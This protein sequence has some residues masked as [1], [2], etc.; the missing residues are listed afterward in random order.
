M[1][2]LI[3]A[4]LISM[5]SSFAAVAYGQQSS[6]PQP[7]ITGPYTADDVS[8]GH[9]LAIMIC[10]ICHIAAADQ[11]SLPIATP[12]APPFESLAQ[13]KDITAES[14]QKF[15]TTTHRGLNNPNG[16]PNPMLMDYQMKQIV[17]YFLSLRI[18]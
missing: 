2:N 18:H 13:R 5:L 16:M 11:P 3:F 17:A 8:K 4:I 6:I 10:S 15:M 1:R 12:P 14:L 9:F 7:Q